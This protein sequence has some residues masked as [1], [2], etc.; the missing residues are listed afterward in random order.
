M[1]KDKYQRFVPLLSKVMENGS[2][3]VELTPLFDVRNNVKKNLEEFHKS[4]KRF[5]NPHI[6]KVSL[7]ERLKELKKRLII[8][9]KIE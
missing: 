1:K 5:I 6:Y 8:S 2:L 9:S 7:S 3:C 4:Y